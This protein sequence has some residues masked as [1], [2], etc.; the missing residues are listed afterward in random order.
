MGK[1]FSFVQ[2]IFTIFGDPPASYSVGIGVLSQG[3]SGW[4][5]KLTTHLHVVLRLRMSGGI[6]MLHLYA[7]MV[8]TGMA[9]PF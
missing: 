2:N 1:T 8:Y 5:M 6:H 7:F 3:Y 9:L 4:G